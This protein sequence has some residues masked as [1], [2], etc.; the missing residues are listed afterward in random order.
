MSNPTVAYSIGAV[1]ILCFVVLILAIVVL[2][3]FDSKSGKLRLRFLSCCRKSVA[4][5]QD[6]SV[7]NIQANRRS[8]SYLHLWCRIY[9]LRSQALESDFLARVK[10]NEPD[11]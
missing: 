10:A 6:H 7:I 9:K 2:L 3:M 11:L 1:V 5:I 4:T 8:M